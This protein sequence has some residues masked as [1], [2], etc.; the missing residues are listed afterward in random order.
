MSVVVL[1]FVF[2]VIYGCGL[3]C[4][5]APWAVRKADKK[6]S[7]LDESGKHFRCALGWVM[8]PGIPLSFVGGIGVTALIRAL[9][10]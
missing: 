6:Y 10:G 9:V 7:I 5:L 2:V 1:G 8:L 4:I 3:G